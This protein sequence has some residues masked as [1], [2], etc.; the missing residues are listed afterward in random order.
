MP[1]ITFILSPLHHIA[2]TATFQPPI[3]L[4]PLLSR[5]NEMKTNFFIYS[6]FILNAIKWKKNCGFYLLAHRWFLFILPPSIFSLS[7]SSSHQWSVT[8]KKSNAIKDNVWAFFWSEE[9][10]NQYAK[11]NRSFGF[12]RTSVDIYF[13]FL[14]HFFFSLS[15]YCRKS[16]QTSSR[17]KFFPMMFLLSLLSFSSIAVDLRVLKENIMARILSPIPVW[18]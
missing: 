9:K 2:V 5:A 18:L 14:I 6:A 17:K 8:N 10:I 3:S 11:N 15:S 7:L 1:S 4:L 16:F 13:T 12:S